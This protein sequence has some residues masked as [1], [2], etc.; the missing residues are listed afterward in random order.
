MCKQESVSR[1]VAFWN[2]SVNTVVLTALEKYLC[3]ACIKMDCAITR[4]RCYSSFTLKKSGSTSYR[5]RGWRF[6]PIPRS[7]RLSAIASP[8]RRRTVI[9]PFL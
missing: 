6:T 5:Y 2:S 7:I 9:A 4:R 3:R 1:V 8:S